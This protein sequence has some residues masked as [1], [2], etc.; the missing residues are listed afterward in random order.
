[1]AEQSTRVSEH[2]FGRLNDGREAHKY[3]IT[4]ANGLVAE[5]TNYGAILVALR[6]PDANQD[7]DDIV[8]GLDTLDE[9]VADTN[10]FG[11]IVGRYANRI[12]DG[13]IRIDRTEHQLSKNDGDNHLHGGLHG[14]NKKLWDAKAIGGSLQLTYLSPDGEEG[15]PGNLTTNVRYTL[16]D[17]DELRIEYHAVTDRTTHC[18]LSHHSYFNLAGAGD[19]TGHRLTI[20]ARQFTPIK[21][22]LIPTGELRSVARTPMDFTNRTEIGARIDDTDP[23]L[24]LGNGYDH[25]WALDTQGLQSPAAT[26]HEPTTGRVMELY[27]TEPGLQ[28]YSGNFLNGQTNGKE[29]KTYSHRGG[30]CLEAQHYPDSPN[31][32][33]FPT[34]ILMPGETYQ[35]TTI[36]RLRIDN[37]QPL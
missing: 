27:T 3:K 14:F 19:I 28:F 6:V 25:N 16:T 1:M 18:N 37:D 15:Y 21:E 35:Q 32:P 2:S 5:I 23:Q 22:G 8:L 29:G 12:A 30:L 17:H 34:T 33:R 10:Y 24:R 13:I 4:N 20:N 7:I 36:Y 26:V 9:Y 11:A 31:Q